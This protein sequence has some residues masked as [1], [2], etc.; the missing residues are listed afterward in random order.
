[1]RVLHTPTEW[2][3]PTPAHDI[4]VRGHYLVV[5]RTM[6]THIMAS[7]GANDITMYSPSEEYEA[8]EHIAYLACCQV[9]NIKTIPF[10]VV[11]LYRT[12]TILQLG[13]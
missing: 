5:I 11:Q 13:D 1:M 10:T 3:N 2:D 9:W 6:R 12:V 8:L 4:E 7:T